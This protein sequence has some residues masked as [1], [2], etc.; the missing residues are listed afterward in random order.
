[1]KVINIGMYKIYKREKNN[2]AQSR[3]WTKRRFAMD[4]LGMLRYNE[5]VLFGACFGYGVF[6]IWCPRPMS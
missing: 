3:F 6:T 5:K 2:C 1:M 4:F